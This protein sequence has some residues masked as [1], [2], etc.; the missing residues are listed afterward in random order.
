V[1]STWALPAFA[2]LDVAVERLYPVDPNVPPNPVQVAPVFALNYGDT[3]DITVPDGLN[4]ALSH[5]P[6]DPN[7]ILSPVFFGLAD[8]PPPV[9]G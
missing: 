7:L 5:Y 3:A 6:T 9:D 4:V 1:A 2:G 8:V